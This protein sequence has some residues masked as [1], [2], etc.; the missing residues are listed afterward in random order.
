MRMIKRITGLL[1]ITC[2]NLF[3]F[4]GCRGIQLEPQPYGGDN[5]ELYTIAA[6]NIP[7]VDEF[8]SAV[9]IKVLEEDEYGRILF[10]VSF[11]SNAFYAPLD[12]SRPVMYSFAICQKADEGRT[13]YYEDDCF[14]LYLTED[15]FTT[16]EKNILLEAND[17]GKPLNEEKMTSRPIIEPH[18]N[19]LSATVIGMDLGLSISMRLDDLFQKVHPTDMTVH[20]VYLDCDTEGKSIG[21]VWYFIE[22]D[23][24]TTGKDAY[25]IMVDRDCLQTNKAKISKITDTLHF[26]EELKQFKETNNW[27]S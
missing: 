14:H 16:K 20:T 21:I 24:N 26:Q 4:T 23:S 1:L 3:L 25:F 9:K 15:E 6:F 22:D 5:M 13:Y 27:S 8:G 17:W 11:S 10:C 2:M 18:K 12:S 19:K 7:Y